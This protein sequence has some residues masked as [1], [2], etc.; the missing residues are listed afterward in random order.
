[1]AKRITQK[2]I[3]NLTPP[4]TGNYI[5]YDSEIPGFGVR[6]TAAGAIAF[7]LNYRVHGRERRYTIG[8]YPELTATAARERALQARSKIL[9][10]RDPLQ[11]RNDARSEPTVDVLASQ[12]LDRYAATHKRPAS[13]R[14]DRQMIEK[15][16]RPKLGK[17]RLTSV[18]THAQSF[19]ELLCFDDGLR[20]GIA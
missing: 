10:G 19:S 4:P 11:E 15:I 6:I 2:L 16:I 8:R 17:L 13:I 9:D 20:A 18:G 5:E 14:N 12:Y 3:S 7:V 1:V